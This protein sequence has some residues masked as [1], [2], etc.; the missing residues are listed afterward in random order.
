MR[1]IRNYLVKKSSKID[2]TIR[3]FIKIDEERF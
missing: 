2:R 1:E 3:I